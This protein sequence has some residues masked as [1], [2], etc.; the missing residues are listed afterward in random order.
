MKVR[1][2]PP[3]AR[4]SSEDGFTLV[5]LLVA[6]TLLGVLSLLLSSS[7]HFGARAWERASTHAEVSEEVRLAQ[8]FL[9]RVIGTAYPLLL[10]GDPTKP[11]VDFD[12]EPDRMSFLAPAPGPLGG[13]GMARFTLSV[14]SRE[15]EKRLSV[16]ASLELADA[17]DTTKGVQEILL[18]GFDAVEFSYFGQVQASAAAQWVSSWN[19]RTELPQLVRARITFPSGDVHVWPELVIAPR[20]VA[21]VGCVYD[22]VTKRCRGR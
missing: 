17:G 14:S 19:G 21:D 7:L 12:G 11:H 20:I 4:W 1:G 15:G 9:R 6:L 5:E 13:S 16:A 8:E 10:I 22:P 2:H 3:S 18:Q